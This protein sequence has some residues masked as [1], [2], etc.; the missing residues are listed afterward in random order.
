MITKDSKYEFDIYRMNLA[1][2]I[3]HHEFT[4]VDVIQWSTLKLR[5]TTPELQGL[6]DFINKH[7]KETT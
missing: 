3:G 5:M 6:A 4:I 7:L 1:Q 2:Q